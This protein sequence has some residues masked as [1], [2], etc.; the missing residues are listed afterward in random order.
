MDQPLNIWRTLYIYL[1]CITDLINKYL[2]SF[3]D[4]INERQYIHTKYLVPSLTNY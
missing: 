1:K 4:N 2:N 3:K